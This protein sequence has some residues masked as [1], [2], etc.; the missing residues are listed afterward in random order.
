MENA[1]KALIIAGAIIL[2]ILII[3]IGMYIFTMANDAISDTGLTEQ[4]A[5]QFNA[6]FKSYEGTVSGS[7]A[8]S[9][10]DTVRAHNAQYVDDTTKQVD[11]EV[12]ENGGDG[13]KPEEEMNGEATD[14]DKS[15]KASDAKRKLKA[16]YTY[17]VT[18]QYD[19]NSALICKIVISRKSTT[20]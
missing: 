15:G 10:C 16:G 4:Q 11:I 19:R 5:Q 7:K 2:S 12:E 14:D 6:K 1:S 20:K 3:G 17:N 8:M 18:I 9:L 13:I